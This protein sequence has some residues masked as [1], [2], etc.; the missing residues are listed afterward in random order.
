MVCYLTARQ[1]CRV[2]KELTL[3][4]ALFDSVRHLLKRCAPEISAQKTVDSKLT[5]L[6][7]EKLNNIDRYIK[8]VKI[9]RVSG[10]FVEFGVALGGSGIF[11]AG[12]MERSRKF[13]GFDLFGMIP[14]PGPKDDEKSHDRYRVIAGGQ[15]NGIGGDNYY[16]YEPDL[17][18]KV[19][20]S[21]S[22]S[23]VPVDDLRVKLV[24]GLF[25]DSVDFLPDTKIA[26]AHIDCDWFDP[27]MFCLE[28]T[29]L[30]M[31]PGGIIILDDYN[32]YG[33]CKEATDEFLNSRSDMTLVDNTHNAILQKMRR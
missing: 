21:F 12:R 5:Y 30:H 27:V 9:A 25:E 4:W 31:P 8:Q 24:K 1:Q 26:F 19:K 23:G 33:G 2:C 3:G 29:Y 10:L 15:S 11:I 6:S 22:D 17:L 13:V 32:D 20:K 18:S 16:G 7:L 14:S 28:K